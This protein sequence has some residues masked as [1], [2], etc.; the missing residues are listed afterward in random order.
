[1]DAIYE[2][3]MDRI[4]ISN[5]EDYNDIEI[6]NLTL[7][8]GEGLAGGY[9][10]NVI[11]GYGSDVIDVFFLSISKLDDDRKNAVCDRIEEMF[12]QDGT[13]I[14]LMIYDGNSE[15]FS[16]NSGDI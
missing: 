10:G 11:V 2:K 12:G 4:I 15:I 3:M 16:I 8:D 9:N 13:L 6:R 14:N 1:M 7:D 5:P